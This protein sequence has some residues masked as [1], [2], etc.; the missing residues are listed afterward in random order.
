MYLLDTNVISELRR[1]EKAAPAVIAWA[2]TI[3]QD[4][5]LMSTMTVF[6]LELG[7]QKKER[8]NSAQGAILRGWLKQVMTEFE[9]RIID[10]DTSVAVLAAR[11]VNEHQIP[12]ADALIAATAGAH[13]LVMVTR[14]VKH[15]QA[16]QL[17]VMNPWDTT[18]GAPKAI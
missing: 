1:P 3:A 7:V 4:A 16:A 5:F 14:N 15:F 12:E 9:G 13:G 8:S 17:E 18:A 2:G 6:E 11:Y 10:I